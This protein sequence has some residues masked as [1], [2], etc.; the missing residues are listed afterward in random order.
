[1]DDFDISGKTG[2]SQV[3]SRKSYDPDTVEIHPAH[4]KPHAWF[5]AYGPSESARIAV[6]VLVEHG[7]HG[8]SGA[9]PV[10]G[11]LI[12]YYLRRENGGSRVS[13]EKESSAG[14]TKFIFRARVQ[15]YCT[16]VRKNTRRAEGSEWKS[17]S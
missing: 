4:L 8:S 11:E 17:S 13:E 10:A 7:E 9:A 2:T 3:I 1:M 16:S 5:V 6:A 15:F 14:R 12:K